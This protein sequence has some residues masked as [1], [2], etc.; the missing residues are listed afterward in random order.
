MGRD[1]QRWEPDTKDVDGSL[2]L[3]KSSGGWDQF[4]ANERLFGLTTDY[5]E[6][7]YTT[8]IDKDHPNY[9]QRIAA[10]EKKAREIEKSVATTSHVAEERIMDFAGGDDERN[11]EDKYSGVRRHGSSPLQSRENKYTPPAR[12]APTGHT[13]VK[14]APV[15]PA[16]ISSQLKAPTPKQPISKSEENKAPVGQAKQSTTPTPEVK[17]V[18]SKPDA[19]PE[20]KAS[21]SAVPGSDAKGTAATPLRPSAATSRTISPQT[22]QGNTSAAPSAAAT[23]EKDVLASFKSFA[24]Q[25]RAVQEKNRSTKAKA[26]KEVKLIELKKFGET[27][28]LSTPVPKDLISII[29]KD[30]EKQKI[31]QEKAIQDAQSV[32]KAKAEEA[33]ASTVKEKPSSTTKDSQTKLQTEPPTSTAATP[34]PAVDSRGTSRPTAPQHS[35]SP[36]AVPGRHPGARQSY[37][38]QAH[39]QQSYRGNRQNSQFGGQQPP[40]TGNLAQRIRENKMHQPQHQHMNQHMPVDNMRQP[41]T[42]PANNIDQ[43]YGR[44]LSGLPPSHLQQAKLNPN[45]HEFRPSA[46]A[47]AFNPGGPSQTSSPR[48]STNNVADPP[49]VHT[50]PIRAQIIRRKTKAVNVASCN[51]L[52]YIKTLQPPAGAPNWDENLGLRPSFQTPVTWRQLHEGKE[53]PDSTMHL[54]Y[55]EYFERQPLA[56]AAAATPIPQHMAPA[57]AHQHQ[58]PLHLQAGQNMAPRQ[59]PHMAPMQMHNGQHGPMTHPPPFA[60]HP[61]DHRMMHSNSAQSFASPRMT[62]QMQMAYTHN[63]NSPAQMPYPQPVMQPYMNNGG[64]HMNPNF[65]SFSTNTYMPQQPHMPPPMM[66]P[67]YMQANG[68]VAGGPPQMPMYPGGGGQFI[69]MGAAPPPSVAGSNGFP[70]PGRPTAPMMAHQ[71]SQ[72]GQPMMYGVSPGMQYQQP[73]HPQQPPNKYQGQRP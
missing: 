41:P 38:P 67:Q 28:K 47:P 9:H 57:I 44:R 21:D 56:S 43:P 59:S 14:G 32:A 17:V 25:Q 72:P 29:A 23:V 10:A 5:D 2:T 35:S 1:L 46:F 40:Q 60:G 15:D 11:E 6:S 22:S 71:G 51:I 69:P 73:F 66:Q 26:D 58:L 39:Y 50:P 70:S 37:V 55:K 48:S 19:K 3:E 36:S 65:R 54:T 49:A 52:L 24:S 63:M 27:F 61:D 16:I 4:A 53:K 42:G 12:R 8:A 20:G 31:I 7:I 45:S 13:T 34:A 33:A 68:M 62:P 64:Q 30:P 18:E